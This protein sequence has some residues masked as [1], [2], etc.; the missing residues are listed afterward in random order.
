MTGAAKFP[1]ERV[2][3]SLKRQILL[4]AFLALGTVGAAFFLGTQ[5]LRQT[6]AAR[7]GDAAQQLE[8]QHRYRDWPD[9]GSA[10]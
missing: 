1:L 7:V 10:A 8:R 6:E 3:W 9:P 4:L 2:G 5:V